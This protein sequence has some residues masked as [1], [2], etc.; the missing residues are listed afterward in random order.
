MLH[1]DITRGAVVN[2]DVVEV[3]DVVTDG[4]NAFAKNLKE[5]E[6][7][8][9]HKTDIHGNTVLKLPHRENIPKADAKIPC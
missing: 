3:N 1:A 8:T 6:N 5:T 9:T 4:R 7:Y 2:G